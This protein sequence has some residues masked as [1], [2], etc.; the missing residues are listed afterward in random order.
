MDVTL[1]VN[2]P[3]GAN[4]AWHELTVEFDGLTQWTRRVESHNAGS[5]DGLDYHQRVRLEVEQDLRVRAMVRA[6]GVAVK[7]LVIEAVEDPH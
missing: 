6:A 2:V 4:G 1:L 7:Q 5:T 3:E